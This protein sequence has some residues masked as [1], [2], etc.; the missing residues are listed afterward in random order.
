MRIANKKVKKS[1]VNH[2]KDCT[3]DTDIELEDGTKIVYS[4]VAPIHAD[5]TISV[6]G[7]KM[8]MAKVM[9]KLHPNYYQIQDGELKYVLPS[10][11][12]REFSQ[13]ESDD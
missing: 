1:T 8:T 13:L 5:N 12:V 6:L 7:V 9:V 4:H 11:S 3:V 10:I 2:Y